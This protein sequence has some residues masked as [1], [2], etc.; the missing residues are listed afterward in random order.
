MESDR[1]MPRAPAERASGVGRA[2]IAEAEVRLRCYDGSAEG[3]AALAAARE[4]A[5]H[6]LASRRSE[7]PAAEQALPEPRR[8]VPS[9]TTAGV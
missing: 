7:G 1:V 3:E 5:G 2:A 9:M 4:L 8:D 6:S